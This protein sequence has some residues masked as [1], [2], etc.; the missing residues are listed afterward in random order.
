MIG[1]ALIAASAIGATTPQNDATIGIFDLKAIHS[2]P[3]DPEV[4]SKTKQGDV[5]IEQVRFTTL[6]GV[7]VLATLTY[8]DGAKGAPG[9][10]FVENFPIK[11][12]VAEAEAGFV[13][14]VISPPTGN[15]DPKKMESVGGPVYPA[16][17]NFNRSEEHTSEL[18]SRQYLVCR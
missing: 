2:A 12:L 6:P 16:P 17:F 7:R 18:Q 4:L 9:Y 3:L 15:K 13:G 8:K 14:F 1:L 10:E 11:P 5:T